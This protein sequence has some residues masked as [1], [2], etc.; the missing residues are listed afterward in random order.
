MLKPLDNVLAWLLVLLGGAHFLAGWVP[1]ISILRGPWVGAVTVAIVSM[2]LIN[3]VRAAGK[4]TDALMRFACVVS[5]ALTTA[6]VVNILYR[7]TGNVLH[8]P[9][10]LAV[11]ALAVVELVFALVR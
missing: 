8:Q 1:A 10:A 6:L 9:A 2:G 4:K 11:A 5:T 3:A 7:F